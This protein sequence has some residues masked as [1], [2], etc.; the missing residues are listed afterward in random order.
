[1]G[2]CW[3]Y[4]RH[5]VITSNSLLKVSTA[6]V[7]RYGIATDTLC[8]DVIFPLPELTIENWGTLKFPPPAPDRV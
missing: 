3:C 4:C 7:N 6:T 8:V 5:L 2:D 1:M